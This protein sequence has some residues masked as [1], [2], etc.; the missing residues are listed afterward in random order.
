MQLP[1][2]LQLL[3]GS[4]LH[5]YLRRGIGRPDEPT[6]SDRG[7]R[8]QKHLEVCTSFECLVQRRGYEHLK[9]RKWWHLESKALS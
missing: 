6:S 2:L 4:K 7:G 3:E 9:M 5:M 1:S 8:K